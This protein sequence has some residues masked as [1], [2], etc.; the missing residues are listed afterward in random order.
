MLHKDG[1]P[2]DV[3]VIRIRRAAAARK[4]R[5]RGL[6]VGQDSAP[7]ARLVESE[8]TPTNWWWNYAERIDWEHSAIELSEQQQYCRNLVA[9][10]CTTVASSLT[11]TTLIACSSRSQCHTRS[12]K[13]RMPWLR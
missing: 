1:D 13:R 11:A 9:A 5:S 7:A 6:L 12:R 3:A 4:I 2:I 8:D 10:S